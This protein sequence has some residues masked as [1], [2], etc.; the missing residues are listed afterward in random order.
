MSRLLVTQDEE[1]TK[2]LGAQILSSLTS[3]II[4][5]T[6]D[7]GAGKT[8]LTQGL[9]LALGIRRM[10]SPT[11]T[12]IRRYSI[13]SD[14][15]PHFKRLYHV[16]LYRL[17]NQEEIQPLGL[18]EILSDKSNLVIIEWPQLISDLL[19][20]DHLRVSLDKL[21]DNSRQITFSS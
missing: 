13:S 8:T 14:L 1:Q 11:Y 4:T 10:L 16:D 19:P 15:V 9:G 12:I 18:L 20:P 5:L 7:L 3:N 2:S 6:G 17:T 21:A